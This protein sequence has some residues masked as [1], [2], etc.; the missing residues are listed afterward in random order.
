M[1]LGQALSTRP[2][3]LP[4]AYCQELS[5][6]QDQIPPFPT[7]NAI[8][9]IESELGSRM[10]DLFADISPAPIAAAS[11]GQVYK[12]HLNSGELVAI[13]VQ[14]PGMAPLLTLDALLFNM[15]GGQLKRFAKARKDLLVAVNEIVSFTSF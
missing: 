6:L 5:K 10:S 11:L 1:Q 3:I 15:I 8:R 2:D 13:K 14:R 12:V 4:S 7:R 9:T